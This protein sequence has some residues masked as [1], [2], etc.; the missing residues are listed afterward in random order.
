[1]DIRVFSPTELPIVFRALRTVL[2]PGPQLS[3][4]ERSFLETYAR[5]TEFRLEGD[6]GTVAAAEVH[7][8]GAHP[9]KRLIQLGAMAVL[10]SRPVRRESVEYLHELAR[11]L[12]VKDPVLPMLRHLRKGHRSLVRVLT[13]R[14]G[15]R[16][17]LKEAYLEEGVMGLVRFVGAMF[18]KARVNPER[19]WSYKRLGLLPEGTLGREY[20]KH[21]TEM[22]FGFP[23]EPGGIPQTVA[24]HDVSHVLTGNDTTPAGEIQQGSLQGGNRRE[25]GFFFVQFVILHFHQGIKITPAAPPFTGYFDP[26]KVLWAIH[27]GATC[28]IDMTHQWDF[29]PLMTLPLEQARTQIGLIPKLG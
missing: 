20:W 13:L 6:P 10:L 28:P 21:L 3:P 29:W 24:Y 5:I 26:R 11:T 22:G 15:L 19:I 7:V 17:I 25:D 1:M 4:E 8:E 2:N 18:F 16:G 14:R 12:E 23:G 27:R 9:R